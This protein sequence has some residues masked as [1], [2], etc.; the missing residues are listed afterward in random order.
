LFATLRAAYRHDG[1]AFVRILQRCPVYTPGI[2]QLAVQKPDVVEMLVHDDGVTVPELERTYKNR[3][4]HDPHD[5]NRARELALVGDRVRLGVFYRDE[6][7]VKYDDVRRVPARAVQ[8]RLGL[9]NA[10][11]DKYAV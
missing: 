3:I 5:L 8:E 11:L 6:A 1:L 9:L 4:T 10:E 7:K 2:Y